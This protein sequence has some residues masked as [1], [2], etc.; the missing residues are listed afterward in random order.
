MAI[1]K[2]LSMV[3]MLNLPLMIGIGFALFQACSHSE[4]PNSSSSRATAGA[5]T[6]EDSLV[7][8][9]KTKDATFKSDSNSPIPPQDR[10]RFQGLSYYPVNPALRF[11]VRLVR[12]PHPESLRLA[13]STGEMRDA[14]RYGY[15]EFDVQGH[16][17]R[18]QVYR[19][20]EDIQAGRAELFA[21][22]R[23]A[24]SGRET[25]AGGRY[26]D[27]QENTSGLYDLDFNQAY[28]PYC[29]YSERYSCPLPPAENTLPVAIEAGE[30]NYNKK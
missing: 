30:R 1:V 8:A 25:Y 10:E 18:L 3:R 4:R 6:A 22:F 15:F 14:L 16:T 12:Y 2:F 24:T 7:A 11:H 21:P 5:V 13:T 26:I 9:R 17:C 28:N 27:L 23:D 29:A 19:T 20:M